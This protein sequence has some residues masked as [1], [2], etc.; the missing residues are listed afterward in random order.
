M[1]KKDPRFKHLQNTLDALFHNLHSEGIGRQTKQ[2][3]VI[4]SEEE[5]KLWQSRVMS[6]GCPKGLLNGGW[7][8]VLSWWRPRA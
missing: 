8:N 1:D 7:E 3:E 5:E 6:I 4:T 2:A